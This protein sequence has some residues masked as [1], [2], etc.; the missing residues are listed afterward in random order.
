MIE[1]YGIIWCSE[2]YIVPVV[3]PVQHILLLL[4]CIIFCNVLW[5]V[6]LSHPCRWWCVLCTKWDD[7][8]CI[9]G[10]IHLVLFIWFNN[11]FVW[12]SMHKTSTFYKMQIFL[13]YINLFKTFLYGEYVKSTGSVSYWKQ[14]NIC[15]V[16]SWQ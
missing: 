1:C 5:C 7:N 3:I 11:F 6:E 2:G 12:I 8:E 16:S 14:F 9:R 15:R 10:G 13:K 4:V